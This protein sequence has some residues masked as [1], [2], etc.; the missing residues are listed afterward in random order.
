MKIKLK[1]GIKIGQVNNCYG[2]DLK[3]FYKLQS[4]KTIEVDKIP[5]GLEN[6]IEKK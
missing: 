2:L 4:G 3:E 5:K 1:P 6:K